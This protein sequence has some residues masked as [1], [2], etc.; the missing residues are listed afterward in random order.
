MKPKTTKQ[1]E[2]ELEAIKKGD[3]PSWW[4]QSLLLDAIESTGFWYRES[5]S[6]TRWLELNSHIFGVKP[7]MLW[8]RLTAGRFIRQIKEQFERSGVEIPEPEKICERVGPESVELLAK[9]E[10]AI[11]KEAF[12]DLARKVFAG[13]VTKAELKSMW[14]TYKPVLGGKTARGRDVP[15]PRLNIK[16]PDQYQSLMEAMSLDSLKAAGPEWA[17]HK[18]TEVY[19]IVLHVAPDGWKGSVFKKYLYSAIAVIKPF[20]KDIEY[21]GFTQPK[22]SV[23]TKEQAI[24]SDEAAFCD[25][26]WYMLPPRSSSLWAETT[27]NRLLNSAPDFVG[28]VTLKDGIVEVIKRAVST[29]QTGTMRD[30]LMSALYKRTLLGQ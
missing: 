28:L 2:K 18:K 20:G 22:L 14:A 9:I 19:Q 27:I 3:I 11:Q 30:K 8:R 23:F 1:I 24:E 17:G 6:F 21:H 29:S 16:D 26:L 7:A 4:S 15:P 12:P 13:K 10:R 5:D 25:F